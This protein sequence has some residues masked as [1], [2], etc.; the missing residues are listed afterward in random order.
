MKL[1]R[2]VKE[3]SS[4]RTPSN[5]SIVRRLCSFLPLLVCLLPLS[6][7]LNFIASSSPSAFRWYAGRLAV[8]HASVEVP[9]WGIM[10]FTLGGLLGLAL[11]STVLRILAWAV[12]ELTA[13]WSAQRIYAR[14]THAV[15]R[16]RTTFFDENP[17]GRMINRLVSDY[18]QVRTVGLTSINDTVSAWIDLLSI[19]LLTAL[20]SLYSGLLIVPLLVIFFYL[21]RLRAPLVIHSRM[22]SSAWSGKVLERNID[23]IGGRASYLLYG[24]FERL[25]VRLGDA[26]AGYTRALMATIHIESVFNLYVR[27]S[28]E[29]YIV[30]VMIGLSFGLFFGRI[31]PTTAGVIISALF[32]VNGSIAFLEASSAQMARQSAHTSRVFE[33]VDLPVE[34]A[35]EHAAP[36]E[37]AAH[38]AAKAMSGGAAPNLHFERLCISYRADSPLILQDF[39]LEIGQGSKIGLIGRTGSG[40]TSVIQALFRLLHVHSGDIY[41]NGE[42]L[43][44]MPVQEAR[45]HFGVVPQFPYLFEGSLRSNLDRNDALPDST[46]LAALD[47]VGMP[48]PLEM[49]VQEGGANLSLGQRQLLCLAR[50]IAGNKSIILLDEATSGLDPETDARV[51]RTLTTALRHKTVIAV[52]HRRESLRNYDQIIEMKEGRI[53]RTGHP[54]QFLV[55]ELDLQS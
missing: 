4:A 36:R 54:A 10:T 11:L 21:Q 41:L 3:E 34:E 29:S 49:Q 18:N 24:H 25:V 52:A 28:I 9:F 8:P 16:A 39:S 47:A 22:V 51:Q 32:A 13:Q 17:S 46:L 1:T 55:T 42:S 15:A 40:K 27:M 50:V 38:Q 45:R 44:A 33:Y 7:G 19:F 2:F 30:L 31:D 6:L 5:L 35:H 37:H 20:A 12:F 48:M 23:L 53:V 43:Y 26:F 14:L